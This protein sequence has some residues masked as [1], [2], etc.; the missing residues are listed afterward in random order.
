MN[1]RSSW[2]KTRSTSAPL[3]SDHL[4]I[5]RCDF[6]RLV[7]RAVELRMKAK[8]A[9]MKGKKAP[10]PRTPSA[11][12]CLMPRLGIVDDKSQNRILAQL[13]VPDVNRDS[14]QLKLHG[15]KLTVSGTRQPHMISVPAEYE[16]A[17]VLHSQTVI[18][19]DQRPRLIMLAGDRVASVAA[20]CTPPTRQSQAAQSAA[21]QQPLSPVSLVFYNELRYGPFRRDLRVPLGTEASQ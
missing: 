7:D 16:A 8:K 1:A 11:P 6:E 17:F 20:P 13:E 18:G 3:P 12:L 21:P 9:A 10:G 4:R 2:L 5:R 14:M 15:D 19:G